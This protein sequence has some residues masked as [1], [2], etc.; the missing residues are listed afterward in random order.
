MSQRR[1]GIGSQDQSPRRSRWLPWAWPPCWCVV[2]CEQNEVKREDSTIPPDKQESPWC[3]CA[4]AASYLGFEDVETLDRR[5]TQAQDQ[6]PSLIR[7]R[8]MINAGKRR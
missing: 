4:E 5:M 2:R 1:G 8:G 7:F 6:H 3:T